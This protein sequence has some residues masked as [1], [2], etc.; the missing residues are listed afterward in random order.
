MSSF[1]PGRSVPLLLT[2]H[3]H[4]R[5][6]STGPTK[7]N[8]SSSPI[9][10]HPTTPTASPTVR[11]ER[12]WLH[13]LFVILGETKVEETDA[14][15][16][17]AEEADSTPTNL[18]DQTP[19]TPPTDFTSTSTAADTDA[20]TDIDIGINTDTFEIYDSDFDAVNEFCT[21]LQYLSATG[22][23]RLDTYA[24]VFSAAARHAVRIWPPLLAERTTGP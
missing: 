16:T 19:P 9:G 20:N 4:H 3:W 15:L 21:G 18:T 24:T 13:S 1:P 6:L 23:L 5:A 7:S 2:T 10:Q 22:H 14:K 17:V 11:R 12:W 8:K